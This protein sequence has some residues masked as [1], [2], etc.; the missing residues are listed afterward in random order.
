MINTKT[1]RDNTLRVLSEHNVP[2]HPHLPLLESCNLRTQSQICQRIVALYS[3]AGLANGADRRLLKDWLVAE[4]GWSFLSDIEQK[5]LTDENLSRYELNEL[6]WKQESLY[7]LCWCIAIV[8]DLVWPSS[9]ANLDVV[10]P[11]IP[12]EVSISEFVESAEIRSE[13]SILQMLDLYYCIHAA[14]MHPELW[15]DQV[16]REDLIVEVILERRQAL[17][18]VC[19]ETVQWDEVSLDT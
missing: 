17:E 19:S 8:G 3:L 5:N 4:G 1:I 16:V 12:P 2:K 18:W 14:V 10:F 11:S 7:V 15:E 9:E 13:E 6:S